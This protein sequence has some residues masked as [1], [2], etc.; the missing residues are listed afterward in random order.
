MHAALDKA[1]RSRNDGF[2]IKLSLPYSPKNSDDDLLNMVGKAA[3]LGLH[4]LVL[5]LPIRAKSLA[6]DMGRWSGLLGL[7]G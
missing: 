2:Q 7:A 1:G 3:N 4:E 5:Q 6:G